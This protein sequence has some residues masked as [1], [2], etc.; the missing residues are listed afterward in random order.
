MI[1]AGHSER[2]LAARPIHSA[3]GLYP[4]ERGDGRWLRVS[5]HDEAAAGVAVLSIWNADRCVATFRV[6]D[7]DLTDLA[8]LLSGLAANA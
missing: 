3:D 7:G 4:D 2:V 1:N 5:W 6:G 8:G